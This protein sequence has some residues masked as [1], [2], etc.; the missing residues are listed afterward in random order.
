MS[1]ILT[2]ILLLAAV[3]CT[4]ALYI[5]VRA[6]WLRLPLAAVFAI[7]M[8]VAIFWRNRWVGRGVWVAGVV[9]VLIWWFS[10][11]PSNTRNWMPD[12]AQ[13]AWVEIDGDRIVMHNIRYCDY[14]TETDYTAR[15]ETR[16]YNLSQLRGIDLF[17]TY[18][19]SPYIAH[20]ILSF[21]F[22]D[23]T[24][25]AFSIETR[26]EV[27]EE[28]SSVLGFFRQ[29]EL[30]FI[31]ADERDVIRLRTNYRKD[32]E[33][34]LYRTTVSPEQ[35][36]TIFLNYLSSFNSLHTTPEWYNA[37]TKN[38][39]T[40]IRVQTRGAVS[41]GFMPWDYRI[42]VNGLGDEMAYERGIL[43]GALPFG[44]LKRRAH[45]NDAAHVATE[46]DFSRLIRQGRPGF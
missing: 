31:A 8:V 11:E 21:Q 44:E 42:L 7:V 30:T 34:Y 24:Q 17:I 45:I 29:Y 18:W 16:T 10:L 46:A 22:G 25:L 38:C 28:Y 12:V 43:A 1:V 33:V 23:D 13:T 2:A 32:E 37:L 14:R 36:R 40:D 15:W 27:G 41:G 20:P 9:A 4:A 19:G 6:V 3:W 35:A 5:D 39:T 26:K